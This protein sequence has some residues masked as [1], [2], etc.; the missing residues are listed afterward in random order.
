[1][2][3][4]ESSLLFSF[5]YSAVII[6]QMYLSYFEK[7]KYLLLCTEIHPLFCPCHSVFK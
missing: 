6:L 5:I 4:K 7:S 2:I 3:C 1:M